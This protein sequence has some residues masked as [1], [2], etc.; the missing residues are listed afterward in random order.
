[1][2]TIEASA[3]ILFSFACARLLVHVRC[4]LRFLEDQHLQHLLSAIRT[5]SRALVSK[6]SNGASAVKFALTGIAVSVGLLFNLLESAFSPEFCAIRGTFKF[7]GL[8]SAL[9]SFL[10]RFSAHARGKIKNNC[11]F[12]S[13]LAMV[14]N[15]ELRVRQKHLLCKSECHIGIGVA[16]FASFSG[17]FI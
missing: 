11:A 10:R 12:S 5:V 13:P 16:S 1:M 7:L 3:H 17:L 14:L 8:F 9:L 15:L 2:N 4:P 6:H